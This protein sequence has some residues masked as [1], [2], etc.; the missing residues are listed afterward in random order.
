M[1]TPVPPLHLPARSEQ[2]GEVQVATI[3]GLLLAIFALYWPTLHSMA[4][5]WLRSETFAHGFL[6]V[7]I[8]LFLVWR[9]RSE[10]AALT[11]APFWPALSGVAL[12]GVV[13]LGGRI[14][15]ADVVSQL[16][17]IAMVPFAVWCVLGTPTARVLVIPLAFL[18]FAVPFGEFLIPSMIN[19]T[20]DFTVAAL[21]GS[22][23]PVY[24]EGNYF[25]IP[26]GNWSVVE[27]CSGLRYLIASMMI[28]SLFAYLSYRS[29]WRR[30]AFIV[31]SL[32]VPII[33]NWLRAYM[34]VMIAY[35]SSNTLAVGVDHVLYGW[36]FFGLVITLLLWVGAR[37]REDDQLP[38]GVRGPASAVTR[39]DRR[40][41]LAALVTLALAAVWP[42]LAPGLARVDA[43]A[44]VALA[45]LSGAAGWAPVPG[46]T[47]GW[48][49]EL[50]GARGKVVQNF[51]GDGAQVGLYLAFYRDQTA[52][53]KAITTT[54]LLVTPANTTWREVDVNTRSV[55][56][57]G[58]EVGA[59]TSLVIG[60]RQRVVVW[61]WFWVDG[62]FTGSEY[63]AKIWQMWSQLR[64]HG[65]AVGWVVVH[66]AE[67]GDAELATATLRR[68]SASMAEPIA[69]AFARVNAQ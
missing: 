2:R 52:A 18:F 56:V 55:D 31:A 34:I 41:G 21:R 27:A 20:A 5:I 60:P 51:A 62:R 4:A 11:T 66:T 15:N 24:R 48:Q 7:P 23:V 13:W 54:N 45:P 1:S 44:P 26:S 10:L 3:A 30:V 57:G 65:D 36:V 8:F 69:A 17:M 14:V 12:A 46:A 59:R 43:L 67:G 28:G 29:P 53:A 35:L 47:N 22:G 58:E 37:W 38:A 39:L 49:P 40:N 6:V 64:G 42:L 50:T 16:A 9:R 19:A 32:L 33:A 63:T 61:R 25:S 68:F